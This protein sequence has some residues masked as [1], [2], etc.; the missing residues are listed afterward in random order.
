MNISNKNNLKLYLQKYQLSI[1]DIF[2]II[3]SL[4][5]ILGVYF[6]NFID[7]NLPFIGHQTSSLAHIVKFI[8]QLANWGAT[9]STTDDVTTVLRY[10]EILILVM[11]ILPIVV[12]TCAFI[13]KKSTKITAGISA[14]IVTIS[15]FCFSHELQSAL[16]YENNEFTNLFLGS[17]NIVIITGIIIMFVASIYSLIQYLKDNNQKIRIDFSK[18]TKRQWIIIGGS[19][20]AIIILFGIFFLINQMPKS[21]IDN[22]S[23]DFT[24]YDHQG[25]ATLSGE[26]EDKIESIL[27]KTKDI[28]R[29]DI[30]I[31]LDKESYLSNGDKVKISV[32]SDKKNSPIKS[33][34]KTVTVSGLKKSTTYTIDNVLKDNPIHWNGYNNYGSAEIDSDIFDTEDETTDLSNGDSITITLNSDYIEQETTK[35]KI[36]DG[37]DTKK[38]KVSGL[39]STPQISNLDALLSQIDTFARD[40]NRSNSFTKYTVTR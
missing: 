27:S 21:I 19:T 35:G 14:F 7:V 9:N 6:F 20:S 17:A 13:H 24:G 34:T 29:S 15:Y 5:V 31:E 28:D 3:G 32:S 39:K 37:S 1:S 25:T 2:A 4:I 38:V 30:S 23:V 10:L 40:N 26:Y 11:T 33:Q 8:K 36:L 18:I 22:I 16:S 12:I